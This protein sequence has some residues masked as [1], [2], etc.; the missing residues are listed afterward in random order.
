MARPLKSASSRKA[1]VAVIDVR[2][3]D[4]FSGGH[5]NGA[6]NIDYYSYSFDEDISK[7]NKDW[8]YLVYCETGNR[9]IKAIQTF[10]SLGF[11]RVFN[12]I[13][14]YYAWKSSGYP[15]VN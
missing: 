6:K 15:V 12:L 14:G 13:G 1:R 5:I 3:P 8:S 4:E 9:S 7:L 11:T 10:K 2:T